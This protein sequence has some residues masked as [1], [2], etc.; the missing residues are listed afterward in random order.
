MSKSL[1]QK[2]KTKAKSKGGKGKGTAKP[3]L[4]PDLNL[5][6]S[7]A[8][9]KGRRAGAA[10]YFIEEVERLLK[11][12]ITSISRQTLVVAIVRG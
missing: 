7:E 2:K 10:G 4:E 1:A 11:K 8:P 3:K 9:K 5:A 6:S 12:S